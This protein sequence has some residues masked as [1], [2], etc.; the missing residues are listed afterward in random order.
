MNSEGIDVYGSTHKDKSVSAL[1]PHSFASVARAYYKAKM[2]PLTKIKILKRIGA[3]DYKIGFTVYGNKH[4]YSDTFRRSKTFQRS[5]LLNLPVLL[6]KSVYVKSASLSKD[7]P[8]DRI[9]KFHYFKIGLH[10][11]N[12]YLI[13]AEESKIPKGKLQHKRYV[14]SVTDKIK[15]L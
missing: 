6:Q 12:V 4:L 14:Y 9:T 10:G 1:K 3:K 13:I 15:A 8:K 7:R 5:D 11:N 2:R